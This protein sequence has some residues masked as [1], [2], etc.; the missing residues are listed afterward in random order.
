MSK[1]TN[2]FHT[3]F[4]NSLRASG[5]IIRFAFLI[6][7]F[8][9]VQP[10][11]AAIFTV[12]NTGDSGAG[13]LRQAIA[14][15]NALAGDDTINFSLSGCPC[16]IILTSGELSISN[17]GSLTIN[18]LDAKLL[19]VSGNHQSR[20]FFIQQFANAAISDITI[21]AGTADFGGGIAT[22]AGGLDLTLTNVTI[23]GNSAAIRGGGISNNSGSRLTL[24]NSTISGN[25]A[26]SG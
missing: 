21:T 19:S 15:A 23:S 22:A 25:S 7:L 2:P 11:R 3:F 6:G 9:A 26:F 4:S 18:G 14:D 1:F 20:V 13:S 12:T 10:A 8:A 24:N 16:T 17:N 5:L